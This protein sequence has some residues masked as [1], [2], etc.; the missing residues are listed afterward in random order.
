MEAR[1]RARE[2][3]QLYLETL[4]EAGNPIPLGPEEGNPRA[5]PGDTVVYRKTVMV[6]ISSP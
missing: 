5:F 6:N 2:L 3:A 1:Q 4:V